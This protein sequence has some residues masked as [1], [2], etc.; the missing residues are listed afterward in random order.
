MRILYAIQGTGNGHISRALEIIPLLKTYGEVEILISGTQ[1]DVVLPWPVKYRLKGIS[2]TFGKNGGINFLDSILRFRPLT[3]IYDVLSLP[4]H[5]FD[6]IISDYEPV[7]AWAC[8]LKNKHSYGMS[9]Q[10]AFLSSKSPRPAKKNRFAEWLLK[11]Y[12]PCK[13]AIGFH[14]LAYDAFIYPPVIRNA[15]RRAETQDRGHI[16]VYLPAYSDATLIPVFLKIPEVQW[17][18]FSK[19]TQSEYRVENVWVH[20]IETEL[21]TQSLIACHGVLTGGGFETPAEA[22]FLHKKILLVPMA[23]Q[24][25]Q[26]CNALAA[27]NLGCTVIQEINDRFLYHL[28][29]WI[30]FAQP[31]KQNFPNMTQ[32]LLESLLLKQTIPGEQTM[33]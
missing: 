12:A 13:E 30:E 20:P 23:N 27:K 26:H 9:H 16:T 14:F 10:A 7:S 25:E 31:V 17:E 11:Y 18:V 6:W 3:F 4:V 24:Y 21:F 22:M 28:R 1:A 8:K 33:V 29:S 19:H 2:F 15:I 32:A 5:Q